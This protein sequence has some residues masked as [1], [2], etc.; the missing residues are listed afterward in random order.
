MEGEAFEAASMSAGARRPASPS[1]P[2]A[3]KCAG[4]PEG[5]ST[6]AGSAESQAAL[7]KRLAA[8][9]CLASTLEKNSCGTGGGSI[10]AR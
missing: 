8:I 9:S 10:A 4:C 5:R 2:S 6:T 7:L 1:E 3:V